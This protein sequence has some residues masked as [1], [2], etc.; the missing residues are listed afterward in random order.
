LFGRKAGKL[1]FRLPFSHLFG[2]NAQ[3][4]IKH[5]SKKP[6]AQNCLQTRMAI[7]NIL[8]IWNFYKHSPR[9]QLLNNIK[10]R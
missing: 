7:K 4:T 3:R 10:I 8:K 2:T 1:V 5:G 9:L 6:I